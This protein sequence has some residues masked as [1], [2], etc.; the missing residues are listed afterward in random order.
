MP[1]PLTDLESILASTGDTV[2]YLG[3]LKQAWALIADWL[4]SVH[5]FAAEIWR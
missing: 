4:F 2:D 3:Y 5:S 1:W